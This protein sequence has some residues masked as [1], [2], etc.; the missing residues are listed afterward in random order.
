MY[1]WDSPLD[2]KI[3]L[4]GVWLLFIDFRYW[5]M[6]EVK[7]TFYPKWG[8][9]GSSIFVLIFYVWVSWKWG[10][11]WED[12]FVSCF[13]SY[14]TNELVVG[15]PNYDEKPNELDIGDIGLE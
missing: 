7:I 3:N 10:S 13:V 1:S 14:R 11:N 9:C 2:L 5:L 8:Y 6:V 15:T 12:Y 4:V